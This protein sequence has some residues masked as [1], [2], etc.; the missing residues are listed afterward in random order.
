MKNL[1]MSGAVRPPGFC[2]MWLPSGKDLL[3]SNVD[4]IHTE[5]NVP[6]RQ[7]IL[8]STLNAL[9]KLTRWLEAPSA[10]PGDL[11]QRQAIIQFIRFKDILDLT[12]EKSGGYRS[13]FQSTLL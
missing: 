6:L 9:D 10:D 2:G 12:L 1:E 4:F 8:C 7:R 5:F 11:D 13:A 3:M